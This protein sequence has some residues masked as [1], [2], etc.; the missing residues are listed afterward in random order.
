M[1]GTAGGTGTG[2]TPALGTESHSLS[3][4]G[5]QSQLTATSGSW[6]QVILLPH[7]PESNC[8]YRCTIMPG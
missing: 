7:T 5:V 2:P 6:V 4:A 8:D 1:R 3:Q